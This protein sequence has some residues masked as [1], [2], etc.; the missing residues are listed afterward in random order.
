MLTVTSC[1]VL[2]YY[3]WTLWLSDRTMPPLWRSGYQN[4]H[5]ASVGSWT[6]LLVFWLPMNIYECFYFYDSINCTFWWE[7]VI[8]L[9][10]ELTDYYR[11]FF[12][13]IYLYLQFKKIFLVSIYFL[14]CES[15]TFYF[16]FYTQISTIM[17][18]V[19]GTCAVYGLHKGKG[20]ALTAIAFSSISWSSILLNYRPVLFVSFQ[21]Q[22]FNATGNWKWLVGS[23]FN[24]FIIVFS[25]QVCGPL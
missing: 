10:S 18:N 7:T 22:L 14:F 3:T 13:S 15:A 12:H 19:R 20:L 4:L 25:W 17:T 5:K 8:E 9:T 21:P 1:W 11:H 23:F 2:R 6:L 24:K 16:L